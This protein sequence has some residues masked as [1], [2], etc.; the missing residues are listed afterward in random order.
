MTLARTE[1]VPTLGVIGELHEWIENDGQADY[2]S[3]AGSGE[4]T[5]HS[6]FGKVIDFVR[7]ATS[8]PVA[9]LTNGSMLHY[10]EVRQ[11]AAGANV[12][13]LSFSA[14][15]QSSFE[16][17]NRPHCDLKIKHITEGAS[18][19]RKMFS[20]ELWIEVFIVRGVNSVPEEVAKIAELIKPLQPDRIQ[21]NTAV[22]PPA[23]GFV[24]AVPEKH[25]RELA[26]LFDPPAEV[27]A[28]F[29]SAQ[30]PNVKVNE[31]TILAMLVRRPCTAEQIAKVFGMHRNE[32]SKY[33]GKLIRTG[34]IRAEQKAG[35]V[36]YLKQ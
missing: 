13:K 24:K 7:S 23:E 9:L 27:I 36:Y 22:R 19:F 21:L 11:A 17:L 6:G 18:A 2:I 33:I 1:Y 26:E 35:S 25:L 34:Q 5:L 3:L 15:D 20:G 31:Q 29:S 16:H 30:S 4:P 10:A 28:E 12:V 8:V 32:L 14:W